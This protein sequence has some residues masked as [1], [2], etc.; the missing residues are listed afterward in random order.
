[1]LESGLSILTYESY[2]Q[3]LT[4]QNLFLLYENKRIGVAIIFFVIDALVLVLLT[5]YLDQVRMLSSLP[6]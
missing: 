1:M 6:L 5:L 2:Q 3:G 4:F